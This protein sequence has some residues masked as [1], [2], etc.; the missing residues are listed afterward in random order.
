MKKT[1]NNIVKIEA[2]LSKV[3]F[4]KYSEILGR[5]D[6]TFGIVSGCPMLV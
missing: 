1:S 2:R 4:P 3:L 6:S 5:G